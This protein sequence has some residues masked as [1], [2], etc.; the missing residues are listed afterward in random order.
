M[1]T[2]RDRIIGGARKGGRAYTAGSDRSPLI[3]MVT[4]GDNF[5]VYG[6]VFI[7]VDAVSRHDSAGTLS[8]EIIVDGGTPLKAVYSPVSGFYGAIWD[9]SFARSGS[10]HTLTARVCDSTGKSGSTLTTVS[11]G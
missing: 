10:M 11:V 2:T 1:I 7:L 3:R 5:T 6:D 8:V 4:P 9:S